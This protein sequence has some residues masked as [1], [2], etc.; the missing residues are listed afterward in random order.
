MK[1]LATVGQSVEEVEISGKKLV[2]LSTEFNQLICHEY[3][4]FLGKTAAINF[5]PLNVA[6]RF[7]QEQHFPSY[8]TFG[9]HGCH[10]PPIIFR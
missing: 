5:A 9:F 3:R 2:L 8:P 10:L 7:S 6:S 4:Q 1:S